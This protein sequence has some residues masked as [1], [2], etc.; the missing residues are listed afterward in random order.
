MVDHFTAYASKARTIASRHPVP[1]VGVTKTR[2]QAM[3]RYTEI[4]AEIRACEDE[5]TLAVYLAT[6]RSDIKQFR[7]ELEYLWKGDGEDFLGLSGEIEA[8]RSQFSAQP[9]SETERLFGQF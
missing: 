8:Q 1:L 3:V 2:R 5:D 4:V 6:I 9:E 7:A